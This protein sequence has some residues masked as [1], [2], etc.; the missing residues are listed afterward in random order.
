MWYMK[1]PPGVEHY[2]GKNK[3][4]RLC[5]SLYGLCQ[6]PLNDYKL[7]KEVYKEAGMTQCKADE[8]LRA[9]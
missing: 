5:R 6:S 2:F 7:V 3:V 9:V 8:C 4:L 1:V